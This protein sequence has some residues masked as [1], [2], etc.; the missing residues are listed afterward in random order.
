MLHGDISNNR[1]FNIGVRCEDCLLMIKDNSLMDKVANKLK[2][3]L[4]RAKVNEEALS[5]MNY[6]YWE[7]DMTVSLIIDKENYSP[8]IADFLA[9]FPCNHID[10]VLTNISEVTMRL[11][12]GEL[13]YYVDLDKN[14]L[15]AVNSKYA[16]E[17][18][19]FNNIIKRRRERF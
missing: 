7:T 19:E 6:L 15:S 10:T 17:L 4:L 14:R 5:L 2:N 8:K 13:T 11:N 12:T 1:S 3:K 16:V 18:E 9:D